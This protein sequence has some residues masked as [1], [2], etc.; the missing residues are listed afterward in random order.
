MREVA[1]LRPGQ[2]RLEG[3]PT[4]PEDVPGQE[5]VRLEETLDIHQHDLLEARG[6]GQAERAATLPRPQFQHR[7]QA[8]ALVVDQ[9]APVL[10]PDPDGVLGALHSP[11]LE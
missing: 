11:K 9:G 1:H 3:A 4:G 6:Q 8:D 5:L 2:S 7:L 10:A